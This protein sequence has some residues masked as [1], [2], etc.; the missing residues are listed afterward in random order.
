MPSPLSH[1]SPLQLTAH[2]C[3]LSPVL[4]RL[5]MSWGHSCHQRLSTTALRDHTHKHS[6]IP[7]D[8]RSLEKKKLKQ[9]KKK[10]LFFFNQKRVKGALS[11]PQA[12]RPPRTERESEDRGSAQVQ[13]GELTRQTDTAEPQTGAVSAL[14]P[15]NFCWQAGISTNENDY[16]CALGRP[17]SVKPW[18]KPQRQPLPQ[19]LQTPLRVP[20][21]KSVKPV[22]DNYY[23]VR[24]TPNQRAEE[25]FM[26]DSSIDPSRS[27]HTP[28][29]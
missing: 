25:Y 29:C 18:G 21:V 27:F 4:T 16:K 1:P 3:I 13:K 24:L 11:A 5:C 8:H 6:S 2:L 28:H 19:T 17:A 12:S 9:K 10:A 7:E 22:A 14:V 15:D 26:T 20:R 23:S